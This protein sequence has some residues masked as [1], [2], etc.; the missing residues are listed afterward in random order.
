MGVKL[1]GVIES[2]KWLHSLGAVLPIRFGCGR[3]FRITCAPERNYPGSCSGASVVVQITDS[4]PECRAVNDADFDLQALTFA[5]VG[6]DRAANDADSD[7]QAI[8]F[9]SLGI[10]RF[11]AMAASMRLPGWKSKF[12]LQC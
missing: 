2:I 1:Q 6:I 3:C 7:L 11:P 9:A 8:T 12:P 4:C 5:S 10:D